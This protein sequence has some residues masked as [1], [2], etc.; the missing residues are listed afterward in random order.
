VF[1]SS[2]WAE[3]YSTPPTTSSRSSQRSSRAPSGWEGRRVGAAFAVESSRVRAIGASTARRARLDGCMGTGTVQSGMASDFFAQFIAGEADATALLPARPLE[4]RA[5]DEAAARASRRRPVQGVVEELQRQAA[6][7]PAS[8]AR[9]AALTAL[10]RAGATCIVTGQQV[11]V[12]LG[13]LY[14]VHKAA[15]AVARARWLGERTGRPCI[16]SSGCRPRITTD[17]GGPLRRLRPGNGSA[18]SP[19]SH[20]SRRGSRWPIAACRPRWRSTSPPS[21]ERWLRFRT[22]PR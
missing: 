16:R 21:P 17:R 2:G 3:T 6:L 15:T 14:T 11:S 9:H 7:L 19:P 22:A 8:P 4:P 10:D 5:W 1:S 13:P 12:F 18:G 20:R